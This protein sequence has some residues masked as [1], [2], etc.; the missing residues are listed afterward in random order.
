MSLLWTCPP[1][2]TNTDRIKSINH[3]CVLSRQL[4]SFV[5]FSLIVHILTLHDIKMY[6][7]FLNMASALSEVLNKYI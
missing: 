6:N 1:F 7:C 4:S 3:F 5:H 2:T